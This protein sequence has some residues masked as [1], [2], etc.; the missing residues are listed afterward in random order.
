MSTTLE[1]EAVS[2]TALVEIQ[3]E[4]PIVRS[5]FDEFLTKARDLAEEAKRE[6]EAALT[7]VIDSE[8]AYQVVD[9]STAVF[10]G[11]AK[12]I[13]E[14]RL[15]LTR[16][17]DDFK[18]VFVDAEN[19]SAGLYGNTV[20]T[21]EERMSAY[22]RQKK[23]DAQQAQLDAEKNLAQR[24]SDLES[25]AAKL[26]H[27][28]STLK[29]DAA[30][31]RVLAEA[32]SLRQT[33]TLMPTSVALVAAEPQNVA[34]DVGEKWELEEL[35]NVGEFLRW[36]ADHSEWHSLVVDPKKKKIHFPK[37]ETNRMAKQYR[38]VVPVPGAKFGYK[39]SFRTKSR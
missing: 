37:G 38:D 13:H 33:A 31:G 28:A 14:E 3:R 2:T 22:R 17:I 8:A 16:L 24:R 25:E 35:L 5:R 26:E 20:K 15:S 21:L 19:E 11:K 12:Q 32:E 6:C 34:N 10:K 36:L 29:T 18:Q 7:H 30:R 27:H 39:D 4:L 23:L 9:T 1:P